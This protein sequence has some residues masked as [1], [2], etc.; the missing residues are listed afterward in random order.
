MMMDRQPPL[1]VLLLTLEMVEPVQMR[2]AADHAVHPKQ[3]GTTCTAAAQSE[4]LR[5]SNPISTSP[6]QL[7]LHNTRGG[8]APFDTRC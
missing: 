4:C 6:P 7:E 2:P 1:P 8:A 3:Q 5:S